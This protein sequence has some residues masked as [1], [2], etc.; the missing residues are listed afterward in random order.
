MPGALD[1]RAA[2]S[3]ET[4][5]SAASENWL[6]GFRRRPRVQHEVGAR[7]DSRLVVGSCLLLI[8]AAACGFLSCQGL[9]S[10]SAVATKQSSQ[11]LYVIDNGAVSAYAIDATTLA[12]SSL[13]Q[14]VNLISAGSL[15][16]FVPA[17]NQFLYVLW[18]DGGNQRHLSVYATDVSGIPQVP[19]VQ[20]LDAS[21]LTQI[22]IHP[23]ARFAYMM[24]ISDSDTGYS[25]TVRLFHIDPDTGKL[26]EDPNP[27]GEYGP[28]NLCPALLYGFRGDGDELYLSRQ[29]SA[30]PFYE[31]RQLNAQTG[32]LG[33]DVMLYVPEDGWNSS[34]ILVIGKQIMIDEHRP[35]AGAGS[36][37]V[38]PLAPS[39]QH[40]LFS[41]TA[42]M[43][44]SCATAANVQIDPAGAYVFLTDI[45]TQR[46]HI[47]KIGLD[48]KRLEDTGDFI[49]M[50]AEIPGFA[51]S[52][53]GTLVYAL[54]AEDSSLHVYGFDSASGHVRGGDNSLPLA[55][56]MG[57][58]PA[59]RK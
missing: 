9:T 50:T 34:D 45:A 18:T 55:G 4:G 56:N 44:G 29:E 23:T 16:Q 21:S 8:L 14:P 10:E 7:K 19:A 26:G 54:L 47:A 51:F 24:Q 46:I 20:T 33:A 49:A 58:A 25:S 36:L 32:S 5:N 2:I 1:H 28:F 30:G 39:P 11:L 41:C 27:Q 37:D 42:A 22:S 40:N 15:L 52:P 6:H 57:F 35:S 59:E 12:F 3:T 31:Q 17:P 53:D 43:L 48:S 38:L 13:G